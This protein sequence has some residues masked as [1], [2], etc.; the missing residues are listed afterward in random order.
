[1]S[2]TNRG[3]ERKPYD[4]YATPVDVAEN[5]LENILWGKNNT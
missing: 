2:A 5:L 1:M 4:F 3:K